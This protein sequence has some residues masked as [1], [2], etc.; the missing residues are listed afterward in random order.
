MITTKDV[1]STVKAELAT[2]SPKNGSPPTVVTLA[3]YWQFYYEHLDYNYEYN[4]GMLE[5]KPMAT[6]QQAE[7]YAWF[8]KLLQLYLEVHPVADLSILEMGFSMLQPTKVQV[9]KPDLGIVLRSNPIPFKGQDHNY[10]GIFDVC[11]EMVST[12]SQK[13][14]RRDTVTKFREYEAAGVPEYWILSDDR[15]ILNYY[16]LNKQGHYEAVVPDD[17]GI[18]ASKQLPGFRLRI[19]DLYDRPDL[20]D[21]V[22]DEVYQDFVFPTYQQERQRA[23]RAEQRAEQERLQKEKLIEFLRNEGINP[24]ELLR[25]YAD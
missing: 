8:L 19:N 16:Q 15:G 6:K 24:D 4:N 22:H 23:D 13:E 3:E 20:A 5:E 7:M 17:E 12:S 25:S 9:R 1:A 2:N 11:V 10:E 21:L 18:W 14:I